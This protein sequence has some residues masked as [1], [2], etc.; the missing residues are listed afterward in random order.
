MIFT[1]SVYTTSSLSNIVYGSYIIMLPIFIGVFLF[2]NFHRL[3]DQGVREKWDTLYSKLA[4]WKGKQVLALPVIFCVRR[5]LFTSALL[6]LEDSPIVQ[7]LNLLAQI[8]AM[9]VYL[10]FMKPFEERSHL[11]LE[12]FNESCILF[13]IYAMLG[14]T[15]IN[16]KNPDFKFSLGWFMI[17]VTLFNIITNLILMLKQSLGLFFAKCKKKKIKKASPP[18]LAPE[19]PPKLPIQEPE[20][21][22]KP[23]EGVDSKSWW[24]NKRVRE[25]VYKKV[26]HDVYNI[27]KGNQ[28]ELRNIRETWA[29]EEKKGRRKLG[30][31][32][33][34]DV[35]S[36]HFKEKIHN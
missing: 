7:I 34:T 26:F 17:F 2:K 16:A 9:M 25:A 3:E 1:E 35:L 32:T 12:M 29:E 6:N 23:P 5:L 18:A 28:T 4:L 10:S 8:Y 14:L 19:E 13:N 31:V 30:D 22:D 24:F 11:I 33:M 27:K 15:D 36:K 21:E 20:E